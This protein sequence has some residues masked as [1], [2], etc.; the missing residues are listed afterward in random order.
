MNEDRPAY[1]VCVQP[2]TEGKLWMGLT[3]QSGSMSVTTY[4]CRSENYEEVAREL[5][6]GIMEAGR[7]MRKAEREAASGLAIAT[8]EGDVNAAV[9]AQRRIERGP[10]STG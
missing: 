10:R 6:K 1:G 5:H 2:D 3:I 4:L 8:G 7:Q 9:Q